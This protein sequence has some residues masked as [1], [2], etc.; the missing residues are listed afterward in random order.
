MK[1]VIIIH[2]WGGTPEYCWYPWVKDKL[3]ARGL[4]VAVPALPNTHTPHLSSWLPAVT[5]A[6]GVPDSDL[7]IIT[8]SLG[9]ITAL[10]YLIR[11]PA[12]IKIGGMVIVAGNHTD[13]G[14]S[15][16]SNFFETMPNFE[17]AA[18]HLSK[19]AEL[20]YSA[21][22]PV[23]PP[24]EGRFLEQALGGHLTLLQNR[25]HFSGEIGNEQ[26][27]TELPEVVEAIIQL[28]KV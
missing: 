17:T 26:S 20:F 22:D 5:K 10:N 4:E 11:L 8:H 13:C 1:R 18:S 21:D 23:V 25:G 7:Y 16:I 6:M 12:N 3:E 28:I 19:P 27:C 9:T 15:E 14:F 2:C 24:S